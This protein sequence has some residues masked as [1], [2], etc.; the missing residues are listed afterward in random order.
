MKTRNIKHAD[1]KGESFAVSR[2][3]IT[4]NFW[5]Y[6][7][8]EPDENGIAYGFVMG[9]ENEWGSVDI[10]ELKPYIISYAVDVQLDEVMAPAGYIW[11]DAEEFDL[12]R[13][14]KETSWQTTIC[15]LYYIILNNRRKQTLWKNT[16]PIKLAT[17]SRLR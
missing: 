17:R 14:S 9:F 2:H 7:L 6:Y 12:V 13:F 4:R 1:G 5:E 15:V 8:G 10:N 3:I 16:K 11:E